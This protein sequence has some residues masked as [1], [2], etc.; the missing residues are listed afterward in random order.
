MAKIYFIRHAKAVEEG[1]DSA[2]DA[3]RELSGKGKD[4][5]KTLVTQLNLRGV[6]PKAIL[7]SD[8][9]R[10]EQT[11]KILAQGLKFSS[12]IKLFKELYDISFADF[13]T[14]V[15]RLDDGLDEIFIIGHNPATTEIAEFLSGSSI[16]SVPTS[17]VFCVEFGCK[18]SELSQGCGRAVFFEFPKK[19]QK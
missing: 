12:K 5:A 17:G 2:K 6:S 14:F 16:G 1:K 18:F 15:R 13:L 9:K 11:A 8:A 10:C 4:D 3:A 7:S 19:S